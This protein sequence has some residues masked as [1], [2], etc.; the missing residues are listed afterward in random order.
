LMPLC[1]FEQWLELV[2]NSVSDEHR[3]NQQGA[4]PGLAHMFE[5]WE[6]PWWR[7][8]KWDSRA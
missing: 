8:S 6:I 5:H 7:S 2:F 4:G 1:R 3:W